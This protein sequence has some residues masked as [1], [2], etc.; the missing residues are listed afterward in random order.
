MQHIFSL[1]KTAKYRVQWMM[2]MLRHGAGRHFSGLELFLHLSRI[3][4]CPTA[5]TL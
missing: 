3:H 5:A 4:A 2:G 1:P